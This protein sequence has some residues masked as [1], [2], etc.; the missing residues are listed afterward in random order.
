[1]S[2]KTTTQNLEARFEAS[3]DVMD[4]FDLSKASRPLLKKERVNL[5]IPH[6]MILRIDRIAERKG[7]ARQAQI[8][9]WLAEKL[10]E[11]KRPA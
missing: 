10:N 1:M 3:E 8:K 5:D 11:E 6:W 7:I 2:S 4:Y 9:Q